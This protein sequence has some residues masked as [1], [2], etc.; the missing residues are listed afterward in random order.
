MMKFEN[1]KH[2]ARWIIEAVT[3]IA[4]GSGNENAITDQLVMRDANGMPYIPG[5]SMA[6]ALRSALQ[7]KLFEGVDSN[8]LFGDE[9]CKQG[10]RL[11]ISNACLLGKNGRVVEGLGNFDDEFFNHY[12]VLPVRQHVR[13]THKGVGANQAKFDQEVVYKGTRFVFEMAM[14]GGAKEVW[15][16]LIA[17]I[18]TQFPIIG[19]GSRNGFGHFTVVDWKTRSFDLT[20]ANDREDYLAH[21]ASLNSS[22]KGDGNLPEGNA[23]ESSFIKYNLSLTPENFFLFGAGGGDETADMIPVKEKMID[24]SNPNQP[25]F[26]EQYTLIPG[27]SV[28]G[29]IAHRVAYHYNLL[30]KMTTARVKSLA[31]EPD[32]A[33]LDNYT[34][35]V[36][37]VNTATNLLSKE[38]ITE[39]ATQYNPAV[40]NLFGYV[41]EDERKSVEKLLEWPK[42]GDYE[43]NGPLTTMRGKVVIRDVFLKKDKE[44]YLNHVAIDRFTGG[45]LDGAL[46]T[47]KVSFE[48]NPFSLEIW[49]EQN[50]DNLLP[51][52]LQALEYAIDDLCNA[53]LPLGGGV[54]RGNGCFKGEYKKN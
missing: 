22:F 40:L 35:G 36:Y 52:A 32:A 5:T 50:G 21:S 1:H 30:K 7:G 11:I 47:E 43:S 33:W 6:G 14:T 8:T 53:K 9:A 20:I 42:S 51:E 25:T 12:K 31:Q 39:I 3:P 41:A 18:L 23:Y 2:I 38:L 34:Q 45:A 17:G 10:S 24:W 19:G 49:V 48:Q 4:I 15:E 27:T 54:M 37:Q 16:E 13:I 44:K 28:K 29:A 46:F 26:T